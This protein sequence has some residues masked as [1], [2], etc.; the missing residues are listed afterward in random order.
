MSNSVDNRVVSMEFDNAKFEHN[1]A[2]SLETLKHLD[3]SLDGLS[4]SS[5][6]FDGVSF[7]DV[8]NQ[9]DSLAKR[10]TLGGRIIQKVFDSI[11]DGIV[12]MG[13][14]ISD[15][16]LEGIESG[17]GKYAEKTTAIKTIM[18]ATGEEIEYVE[19]QLGRLNR[20]S[21]ETSYSFTDMT[22]NIGKFTAQGVK[23]E[24]AVT[25]MQGIAT[26]AAHAGQNAQMASRAMYN[27]S[28]AMGVGAMTAIDW[29]SIENASMAT[30]QFKE[31]AI[32]AAV[33]TG[34]LTKE[35]DKFFTTVGKKEVNI[36]NFRETLQQ[37]WFDTATM[38][39][40]FEE[41]GKFADTID[42]LY[43]DLGEEVRV[44]TLLDLAEQMETA[45]NSAETATSFEKALGE[46]AED[47]GVDTEYLRGRIKELNSEE[48]KFSKE[49]YRAAQEAKTFKDALDAT[50]DA[51]GTSWMNLFQT[52]F[53]NYE[54]SRKLWTD[55]AEWAYDIFAEP[56]NS[57][58]KMTKKVMDNTRFVKNAKGTIDEFLSG[59]GKGA[60]KYGGIMATVMK[61][62]GLL[63]DD[64]IKEAGS[65]EKA[66]LSVGGST[67]VLK[68]TI[69]QM[70]SGN[71][72]TAKAATESLEEYRNLA[73]D[74]LRGDWGNGHERVDALKE[75]GFDPTTAQVFVDLMHEGI[76][77]TEADL[78]RLSEVSSEFTDEQRA[79]L[80]ALKQALEDNG[81]SIEDLL[82]T[83]DVF[84]N[85][86]ANW[87]GRELLFGRDKEG[88]EGG[89]R[90]AIYDIM[91]V[92]S[93][94]TASIGDAWNEVF[95]INGA[96][97][98]RSFLENFKRLTQGV[99]DAI[100]DGENLKRAFSGVFA[101]FDIGK[102]AVVSTVKGFKSL[103][104][105]ITPTGFSLGGLVASFGD[106]L[107]KA[108]TWL[109]R[110]NLITAGFNLLSGALKSVRTAFSPATK[111]V[112]AFFGIVKNMF[113]SG[114][115]MSSMN[116]IF[117]TLGNKIKGS[118]G[119][120]KSVFS[121]GT[122]GGLNSLITKAATSMG[123]LLTYVNWFG[124][125]KL[126]AQLSSIAT[127][128]N[129]WNIE[130]KI[131]SFGNS[132]KSAISGIKDFAISFKSFLKTGD[133]QALFDSF[134]NNF[135]DLYDKIIKFK[136]NLK[137]LGKAF[138]E[139]LKSG[140][141]KS[142]SDMIKSK[143]ENST[144]I[145]KNVFTS[146][147]SFANS[148][149]NEIQNG[150]FSGIIE[151]VQNKIAGVI[152]KL[153][154]GIALVKNLFS[155]PQNRN[156]P[157]ASLFGLFDVKKAEGIAK[158]VDFVKAKIEQ[159]KYVFEQFKQSKIGQIFQTIINYVQKVADK[160]INL[161]PA[162]QT[163]LSKFD[164]NKIDAITKL[165]TSLVTLV[166]AMKAIKVIT[167]I[168]KVA[169]KT[170]EFFGNTV[171]TVGD[172]L[173][174]VAKG[175]GTTIGTISQSINSI[176]TMYKK[177]NQAKNILNIAI[178]IGILAAS[179]ALLCYL[180]QDKLTNAWISLGI[181]VAALSALMLVMAG[182]SKLGGQGF[183]SGLGSAMIG[184]SIAL[185]AMIGAMK[186][187]ESMDIDEYWR[188][189]G[190]LTVLLGVLAGVIIAMGY[191]AKLGGPGFTAGVGATL[192]GMVFTVISLVAAIKILTRITFGDYIAS[193]LK[194][195]GLF[196]VLAAVV[197]GIAYAAKIA[198]HGFAAGVAGS[199]LGTVFAILGLILAIKLLSNIDAET[200]ISSLKKLAGLAAV[201]IAVILA[202]ALASKIGGKGFIN[203]VGGSL[204]GTVLAIYIL[205]LT[206]KKIQKDLQDVTPDA[207]WQLVKICGMLV[208][209]ALACRV[210]AGAKGGKAVGLVLAM[211]LSL[212]VLCSII[213]NLGKV[214]RD[215]IIQGAAVVEALLIAIAAILYSAGK[216][217]GANKSTVVSIIAIVVLVIALLAAVVLLTNFTWDQLKPGIVAVGTVLGGLALVFAAVS[218]IGKN[219]VN[220][221]TIIEIIATVVAMVAL[222]AAIV[223]LSNYVTDAQALI[224]ACAAF[225]ILALSL[226]ASL[227]I[228]SK[229]K[230]DGWTDALT[231]MAMLGAFVI[232][233]FA[234]VG[235]MALLQNIEVE[236]MLEKVASL[237]L[238]MIAISACVLIVSRMPPAATA[239]SVFNG[240]LG[241]FEILLGLSIL[242]TIV[243]LLNGID[244]F[245]EVFTSGMQTLGEAIG[246]FV[247]GFV[248]GLLSSATEALMDLDGFANDL[249]LVANN[250]KKF[251]DSAI[252]GAKAMGGL[253][254]A[255]AGAELIDTINNLLGGWLTKLTGNDL[256]AQLV[257]FAEAM[258]SYVNAVAVLDA[259]DVTKVA[260]ITEAMS[261]LLNAIPKD[262]G[263]FDLF[264]GSK[265]QAMGNLK[266]NL[267]GEDGFGAAIKSF[268]ESV[269][270]IELSDITAVS[271]VK[272]IVTDLGTIM[273]S[274]GKSGGTVQ[275]FMGESNI[276]TFG[277]QLNSFI[278]SLVGTEAG[279]SEEGILELAE[280]LPED[281]PGLTRLG[282]IMTTLTTAIQ[283]LPT[284][285]GA[286]STVFGSDDPTTFGEEMIAF[287]DQIIEIGKKGAELTEDILTGLNNI[288]IAA[289]VMK[290]VQESLNGSVATASEQSFD[291]TTSP[292][293]NAASF[294]DKVNAMDTE[295]AEA[296]T[297]KVMEILSRYQNAGG[298][299]IDASAFGIDDLTGQFEEMVS[300]GEIS[301]EKLLNIFNEHS[302]DFNAVGINSI[303]EIIGGVQS[304]NSDLNAAGISAGNS[305]K[306]GANSVT[307]EFVLIGAYY[308]D[309]LVQGLM[310]KLADVQAAGSALGA[311]AASGS[312]GALDE[313]SPSKVGAGIG[314]FFSIGLGNG[315]LEKIPYVEG[316]GEKVGNAAASAI[317]IA[318]RLIDDILSSDGQPTIT[319]VLD[320]SEVRNGVRSISNL[321]S[322]NASVSANTVGAVSLARDAKLASPIQ[323]GTS[324]P[325]TAVLSDSAAL[326]LAGSR[327]PQQVPVIE[328]TGD[329]AQLARILQPKIK[330][331]DNYHGKSLVR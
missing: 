42:T 303:D 240:V 189:L 3:K 330:M 88:V 5:K 210:A 264:T 85:K 328:F 120:L 77:T 325:M 130:D 197:I 277:E 257:K 148:V 234:L 233:A 48:L 329:L 78:W 209:V 137:T 23:L 32:E 58:T 122:G 8:A 283:G 115:P 101:V 61:K 159:L 34:T 131:K 217:S 194:L 220:K 155:G 21:D 176:I 306:E 80:L 72:D 140:D 127:A 312:R 270:G 291:S 268:V 9:I 200:Y 106:F 248:G 97:F 7:E 11:A 226:S 315:I 60:E 117:S 114:G 31:Q 52:L 84:D 18:S 74:I 20:F 90:G 40:V 273:D 212:L 305:A 282:T 324:A 322:F 243:G 132:V 111:E 307:P 4:N 141:F 1:V 228:I 158:V 178:A 163:F 204:L 70:L 43:E 190:R 275:K 203:G 66:M 227:L 113:S 196:A 249:G 26:W 63:T 309:G 76:G 298:S 143:F 33:A 247:G 259:R 151:L 69:D 142:F 136:D 186:I 245:A 109:K 39:K 116:I 201:L 290:T 242:G 144:G 50:K 251:D 192:L 104:S 150:S 327:S 83:F 121:S 269:R 93:T 112:K 285:G 292:I 149:L 174:S 295:T 326:A 274:I 286:I 27:I 213:K 223:L 313:N 81:G 95:N 168:G 49:T 166:L 321:G 30:K 260:R 19:E 161:S 183:A 261:A 301:A 123:G 184:L 216:L 67:D 232:A 319:P 214:P 154:A 302:S 171:K 134:K 146:V 252:A 165:A 71:T 287:V 310:S 202:F 24:D 37:K 94:F 181:I 108:D 177:K 99:K 255:L 188:S 237:S 241:F 284:M 276:A 167:G 86:Y 317:E 59:S 29:K 44:S 179:L 6:K 294:V 105:A 331:Q 147:S 126:P 36:Q 289:E 304:K 12:G 316:A 293:D 13:K 16:S 272:T 2:Q 229:M 238:L 311:A 208:L 65:L 297:D 262:G 51:V 14:K 239:S 185:L 199:L 182:A 156:L 170:F 82:A 314:A 211:T 145:I 89:K 35:G 236:G 172:V 207:Y 230:S 173:A 225:A 118:F 280:K 323:N 300:T 73:R 10:F 195:I 244:G 38:S 47:A 135:S 53:G 55:M 56:V 231:K 133:S 246:N 91:D 299:K 98:I 219:P 191:A 162:M 288:A 265:S 15:F 17:W 87:T 107:V 267:G 110:H 258:V 169:G 46:A 153:K 253:L 164:L 263:L 68:S 25:Q 125:N 138:V 308:G 180:P 119:A 205:V 152:E 221:G 22:T 198:G 103:F 279:A 160:V 318:S 128:I 45:G 222:L 64:M 254:L 157:T 28:Q 96:G 129:N 102:N 296:K 79:Q 235:V 57:I 271:R 281:S 75:A 41:Y 193:L 320:L 54:E 100:G 224:S 278:K 256:G 250:L 175:I 92:I 266:K 206:L 187:L 62:S 124:K 218:L 139:S 215:E